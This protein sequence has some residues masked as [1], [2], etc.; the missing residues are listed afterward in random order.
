MPF[1]LTQVT[2]A[3]GP[4]L[5]AN[6]IPAFWADP[7]WRLEWRH[8]TLEYHISQVALRYP[9]T[10][11]RN[12]DT[13]RHQKAVDDGTGEVLGYARWT[14]PIDAVREV[15]VGEEGGQ[16]VVVWPEAV[17][18]RV[19]P[20]EEEEIQRVAGTAVWDPDGATDPL[21]EPARKIEEEILA[22]KTYMRLDYLAVHPKHQRQGVATALV[23]SG[24][25]QANKLGL[26]VFVRAMKPGVPVYQRL[27]FRLERELIQDDSEYGGPGDFGD[28]FLVYEQSGR[29]DS[30]EKDAP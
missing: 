11:I 2:I 1:T 29:G 28:Y 26:D 3:D 27:G 20:E 12:P 4:A 6:N 19:T 18:P 25:E 7:H 14:I 30:D 9:R 15:G 5:A 16:T 21:L 13:S 23:K 10:L 24:L 8:R 17:G 22:R